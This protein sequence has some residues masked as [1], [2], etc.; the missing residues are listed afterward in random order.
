MVV[1]LVLL[2]SIAAAICGGAVLILGGSFAK[3]LAVYMATGMAAMI[4]IVLRAF[5]A[6]MKA[7]RSDRERRFLHEPAKTGA[8]Q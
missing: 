2:S 8:A 3:A 5:F 4:L 1:G 7:A 6:E